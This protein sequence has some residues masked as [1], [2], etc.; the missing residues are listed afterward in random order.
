[1]TKFQ[2]VFPYEILHAEVN[3]KLGLL[4]NHN[5]INRGVEFKS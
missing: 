3:H 5:N 1:M 2:S 4:Y